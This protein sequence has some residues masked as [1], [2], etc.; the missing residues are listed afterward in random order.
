[1]KWTIKE[2]KVHSVNIVQDVRRQPIHSF[3]S[4]AVLSFRAPHLMLTLYIQLRLTHRMNNN[5]PRNNFFLL[6]TD[7]GYQCKICSV[8]CDVH[9][10]AEFAVAS[11]LVNIASETSSP[12]L[13]WQNFTALYIFH[14]VNLYSGHIVT[15][16]FPERP[17]W[18]NTRYSP[19]RAVNI[20][21]HIL[22][23]QQ[24]RSVFL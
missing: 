4:R 19:E 21:C 7:V 1:M 23:S 18:G 12:Q 2:F 16:D 9:V 3:N 14:I 15:A 17:S 8:M 5:V 11:T 6:S 22:P 24:I 10:E 13:N 20:N